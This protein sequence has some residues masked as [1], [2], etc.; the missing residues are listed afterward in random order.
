MHS[1]FGNRCLISSLDWL[2]AECHR[3]KP[4][5]LFN[6]DLSRFVVHHTALLTGSQHTPVIIKLGQ[7]VTHRTEPTEETPLLS[8]TAEHTLIDANNPS[9]SN[10]GDP[11]TP[12]RHGHSST[13]DLNIARGSILFEIVPY[14]LM[15]LVASPLAFLLFGVLGSLGSGFTPSVQSAALEVYSRRGG[16]ESGRLFGA[17]GVIQLLWC[18]LGLT[19]TRRLNDIVSSIESVGPT[20]YGLVYINTVEVFPRAIFFVSLGLVCASFL[21]LSLVRIARK[22][23]DPEHQDA[24]P[25][26]LQDEAIN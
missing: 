2:L 1:S 17:M 15:A 7:L 13:F 21:L 26:S 24:V 22:A 23:H 9:S 10:Q 11:S 14:T 4:S 16:T 18:V 19:L 5:C 20:I 8:S 3:S 6:L 25:S 12:R